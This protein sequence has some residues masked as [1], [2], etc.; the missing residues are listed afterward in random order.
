MLH[1]S[2]NPEELAAYG[3]ALANEEDDL[4]DVTC[5]AR[6]GESQIVY[7]ITQSEFDALTAVSYDTLRQQKLFT[8][9]FDTVTSIDVTLEGETYTFTYTPPENDEDAEGTWSYNGEEFDVFISATPCAPCRRAAS[10]T[11]NPPGRRKSR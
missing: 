11:R 6:V 10:R 5:Y 4:P 8:A 2:Q 7:Q 9:D 1:L 3:E